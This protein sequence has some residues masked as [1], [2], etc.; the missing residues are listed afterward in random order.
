M[1]G[2]L[3]LCVGKADT[4]WRRPLLQ[5]IPIHSMWKGESSISPLESSDTGGKYF[6]QSLLS[7]GDIRARR[8]VI[9]VPPPQNHRKSFRLTVEPLDKGHIGTRCCLFW[10][11]NYSYEN[12]YPLFRSL[13]FWVVSFVGGS[14]IVYYV[15]FF[16]IACH[17]LRS[18]SCTPGK[19]VVPEIQGRP[20][21][22]MAP[23]PHT[24]SMS[25]SLSHFSRQHPRVGRPHLVH[26]QGQLP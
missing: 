17:F 19:L 4:L 1:S 6:C 5:D 14:T 7:K 20:A 10:R 18:Y 3:M 11:H 21:L 12:G 9:A 16:F 13:L 2:Y 25:P 8:K 24:L 23:T 15:L 26:D 22:C